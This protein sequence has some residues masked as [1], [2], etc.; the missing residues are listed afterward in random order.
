M[1][2]MTKQAANGEC[3]NVGSGSKISIKEIA[4]TLIKLSGKKISPVINNEFREGDIRHCFADISKIR[5]KLGYSPKIDF[6][7]QMKEIE[8]WSA[9][10]L[11]TD[12]AE[13]MQE[14]LRRRGMIK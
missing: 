5:N 14:E 7:K 1:L 8:Q 3:F 13:K 2:D 11:A 9:Q 12:N 6:V 4:E 10:E